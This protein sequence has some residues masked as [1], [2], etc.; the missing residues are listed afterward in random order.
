M[1]ITVWDL[2]LR[3]FHWLL[4]LAVTG[5]LVT[6]NLGGSWMEWHARFGLAVVGLMAFRLV[7]GVLGSTHSRFAN[8]FPSLAAIGR[9]YR[10]QWQGLGHNPLGALSVYASLGLFAFQ[11]I[12]GLFASDDIAFGG[13][14]TRAVSSST[15][16]TLSSWHRQT[17]WWMYLLVGLHLLAIIIYRLRG[18]QLVGPMIHGQVDAHE[19]TEKPRGGGLVAFIVTL[20]IAAAVVWAAN[21]SW[22]PMPAPAPAP[23][24]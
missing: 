2:P 9:Y 6:I 10:G 17:E 23:A 8:F 3:L 15:V 22:I 20:L 14:L 7:W 4:V 11:A 16:A 13:P 21:G 24:W 18:K 5:A 19:T 1:R 12:S